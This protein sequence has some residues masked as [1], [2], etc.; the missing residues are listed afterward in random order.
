MVSLYN[1]YIESGMSDYLK[2]EI[3]DNGRGVIFDVEMC[4]RSLIRCSVNLKNRKISL[5][6]LID[7]NFDRN[8]KVIFLAATND[9]AKCTNQT[10]M[11]LYALKFPDIRIINEMKEGRRKDSFNHNNTVEYDVTDDEPTIINWNGIQSMRYIGLV[12][13]I[14]GLDNY[15][16]NYLIGSEM[17][18]KLS[19]INRN[20]QYFEVDEFFYYIQ[21]YFPA[22][23][24]AI[25]LNL[26]YGC[27][28]HLG[29]YFCT[30]CPCRSYDRGDIS[31]FKCSNCI[32]LNKDDNYCMHCEELDYE[33]IISIAEKYLNSNI[34]DKYRKRLLRHPTS[35]ERLLKASITNFLV[36]V[37]NISI[38]ILVKKQQK[39]NFILH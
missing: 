13:W 18:R 26:G 16:T 9:G 6:D 1:K 27:G 7:I 3:V 22:D 15:E 2:Y 24:K 33:S 4:I 32:R 11:L 5:D 29:N 34:N 12:G 30:M 14:E 31:I 23:L 28:A 37:Y 20:F 36:N 8:S 39:C 19:N 21:I 17:Y 35:Q 38:H 10:G 25:W